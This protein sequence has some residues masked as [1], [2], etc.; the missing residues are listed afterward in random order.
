MGILAIILLV[1]PISFFHRRLVLRCNLGCCNKK[2][3]LDAGSLAHSAFASL[4][5]MSRTLV[6]RTQ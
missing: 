3:V 6:D 4:A 2:G 5:S 1:R